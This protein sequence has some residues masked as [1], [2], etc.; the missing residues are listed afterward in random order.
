MVARKYSQSTRIEWQRTMYPVFSAEVGD[1]MLFRD[2]RSM[3]RRSPQTRIAHIT[4][5]GIPKPA[6][7]FDIKWVGSHLSQAE[8][9]YSAQQEARVLFRLV[10][11]SRFEIAKDCRAI[12]GPTPPIVPC[13]S[14][15]WLQR[16]WQIGLMN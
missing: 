5:K 4:V 14:F 1:G 10:P 12:S 15:K 16:R 2:A 8:L 9:R 13:D 3:P 7:A 11:D 6:D